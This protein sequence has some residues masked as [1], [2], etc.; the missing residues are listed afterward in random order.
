MDRADRDVIAIGAT[1]AFILV[2]GL[3]VWTVTR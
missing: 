2:W 3:I 1:I